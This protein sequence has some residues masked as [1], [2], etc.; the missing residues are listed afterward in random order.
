MSLGTPLLL[1]APAAAPSPQRGPFKGILLCF[2]SVRLPL[3]V[4]MIHLP[5]DVV[6]AARALV[7]PPERGRE[8]PG[9]FPWVLQS[10]GE[11]WEQGSIPSLS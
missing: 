10:H 2:D 4:R 11:L 5:P 6:G 8:L 7:K 3:D 9:R 1:S